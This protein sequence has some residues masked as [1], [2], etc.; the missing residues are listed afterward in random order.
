MYIKNLIKM[1]RLT[2][3][4]MKSQPGKQIFAITYC[5]YMISRSNGNQKMIFKVFKKRFSNDFKGNR[6]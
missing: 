2:S 1:I 6:S 4:F 3:K 5:H